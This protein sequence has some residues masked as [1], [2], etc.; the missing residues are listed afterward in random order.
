MFVKLKEYS[1]NLTK[2]AISLVLVDKTFEHLRQ[3][4]YCF[5]YTVNVY[6]GESERNRIRGRRNEK[7][8]GAVAAGTEKESEA[9]VQ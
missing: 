1:T 8:W 7:K 5:L 3:Y 2:K 6:T 4:I 9:D